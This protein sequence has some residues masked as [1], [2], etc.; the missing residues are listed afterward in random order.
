MGKG[1]LSK[2]GIG[3]SLSLGYRAKIPACAGKLH[4]V[5]SMLEDHKQI[6]DDLWK[7]FNSG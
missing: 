4:N 1:Q 6:G 2:G 7:R 5:K 3:P